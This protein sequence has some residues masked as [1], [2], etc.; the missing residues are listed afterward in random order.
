MTHYE[1]MRDPQIFN[2]ASEGMYGGRC[3]FESAGTGKP[4]RF[5]QKD[6]LNE[7]SMVHAS[8]HAPISCM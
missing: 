3:A 2:T 8:A 1:I 6:T 5:I 4:S 7:G